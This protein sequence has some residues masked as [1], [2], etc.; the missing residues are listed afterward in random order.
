MTRRMCLIQHNVADIHESSMLLRNY[1]GT[2]AIGCVGLYALISYDVAQRTRELGIRIALGATRH[3]V[4]GLVL[5]DG[6]R[7]LVPCSL[8]EVMWLASTA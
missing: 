3:A 4:P 2:V 6:A 5:G 8:C 7:L 1:P